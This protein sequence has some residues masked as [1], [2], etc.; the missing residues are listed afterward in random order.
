M[1]ILNIIFNCHNII[2]YIY[3]IIFFWSDIDSPQTDT[4]R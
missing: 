3:I 4:W 2:L 1:E